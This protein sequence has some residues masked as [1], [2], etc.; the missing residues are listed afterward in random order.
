[1]KTAFALLFAVAL[2]FPMT[3]M[4]AGYGQAYLPFYSSYFSGAPT[5]ENQD[6]YI[7]LSNIAN[8]A[9][10]VQVT[11]F[12]GSTGSIL[13]DG[14][15]SLTTGTF[16]ANDTVTNWDDNPT[17]ASVSFTLAPQKTVNLNVSPSS[18]L[19]GHGI[20]EWRSTSR[21][22]SSALLGHAFKFSIG[23]T[24]V[25]GIPHMDGGYAIPINEGKP[26]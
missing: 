6:T 23:E 22:I 9:I 17:S 15:D 7:C 1:M 26:F 18:Q 14:D 10:T 16:R 8:E 20:I 12:D 19:S 24:M 25:T 21:H 11:L 4:G 3:A 2:F 5:W 13:Q